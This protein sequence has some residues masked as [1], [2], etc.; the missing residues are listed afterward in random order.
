MDEG[1]S[2]RFARD[3]QL[4]EALTE[5]NDLLG[6]VPRPV[7]SG[8]QFPVVFVVG[9]PRSG[10]TLMMQWLASLGAFAYPSNL[11]ARFYANPYVGVRIQQVL[12]TFDK[13]KQIFPEQKSDHAYASAYGHTSGA[14]EP[15]EYWYF[16]RRFFHFGEIQKIEDFYSGRH[17]LNGFVSELALMEKAFGLPLAMKALIINWNLDDLY[18]LFD[19]CLF[20]DVNRKAEDNAE[21][22]YFSR[23]AFFNDTEKWYSFKPPEYE[24]LKALHPL[25]QV[26]GQVHYTRKAIKDGLAKVPTTSVLQVNY[27][28][29]CEAPRVVYDELV[30]CMQSMGYNMP[31]YAGCESFKNNRQTRLS[32]D[33]RGIIEAYTAKLTAAQ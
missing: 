31:M 9:C 12:H 25:E 11:V 33:E 4:M 27:E 13:K 5:L 6:A 3:T 18:K 21:S 10:T 32:A 28:A 16:W 20:I 26:A 17:D 7:C 2:E 30:S 23:Q 19:R 22:L 8:F 29:F 24:W 14:L 15:S 1:R